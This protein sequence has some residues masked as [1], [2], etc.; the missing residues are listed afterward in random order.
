[1][2]GDVLPITRKVLKL[3]ETEIKQDRTMKTCNAQNKMGP[4][5]HEE[6]K[7]G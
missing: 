1:M 5:I 2:T 6:E 3:T 4:K 7:S